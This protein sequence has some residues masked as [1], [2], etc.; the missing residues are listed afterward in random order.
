MY[1]QLHQSSDNDSEDTNDKQDDDNVVPIDANYNEAK[2]KKNKKKR[3]RT[4]NVKSQQQVQPDA[5]CNKNIDEIEQSIWEVNQLL[6]E[7][8]PGCSKQ[9]T[10]P[11]WIDKISKEDILTIEH[12]HLNPYNELKKIFGSKTIQAERRYNCTNTYHRIICN[13]F[14]KYYFRFLC[15]MR[16]YI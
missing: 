14:S 6:G 7:P 2:R 11:H 5:E 16:A 12:K 4:E 3:K 8:V 10:E 15:I 1:P 9:T 13:N